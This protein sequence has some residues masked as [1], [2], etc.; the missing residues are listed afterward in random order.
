MGHSWLVKGVGTHKLA[1]TE[2]D[3]TKNTIAFYRI[4]RRE[5]NVHELI[6]GELQSLTER[7]FLF[8]AEAQRPQ[9]NQARI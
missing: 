7:D 2:V 9:R 4:R 3:L 1:R 5:P 6:A 8:L